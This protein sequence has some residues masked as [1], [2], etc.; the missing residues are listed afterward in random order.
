M[1]LGAVPGPQQPVETNLGL[2]GGLWEPI[3]GRIRGL[4]MYFPRFFGFHSYRG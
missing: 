1:P 3:M 2:R 4:R